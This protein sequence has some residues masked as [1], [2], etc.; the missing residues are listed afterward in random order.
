M[1]RKAAIFLLLLNAI[2]SAAGYIW[3]NTA[4]D[5]GLSATAIVTLR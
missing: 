5:A 2:I 4:L 1:K 3:I